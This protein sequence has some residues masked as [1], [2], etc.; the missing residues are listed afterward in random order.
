[1]R[2]ERSGG[3]R[4]L[5]SADDGSWA[6]QPA[7]ISGPFLVTASEAYVTRGI[8]LGA[9]AAGGDGARAGAGAAPAP[10]APVVPRGGLLVGA[11]SAPAQ[12]HTQV[13]VEAL[14]E[15]KLHGMAWSLGNVTEAA[16]DDGR[17]ILLPRG[18]EPRRRSTYIGGSRSGEWEGT[19]W[20]GVASRDKPGA[21]LARLKFLTSFSVQQGVETIELPDILAAKD[22]ERIV[23]PARLVVNGVTRVGNNHYELHVASFPVGDVQQWRAVREGQFRRGPRLLDAAGRELMSSGG[24][25]S[26]NADSYTSQLRFSSGVALGGGQGE[27]AKLVWEVPTAVQQFTV[28][29]EFENLPLP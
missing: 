4:L 28:P 3:G 17:S 27:P 10:P 12:D 24:S 29:V 14:F 19:V 22:V 9:D 25:S 18:A 20:L 8:R 21:R 13:Q 23:G 7:S 11:G 16:D 6:R 26:M 1:M 5:L 2:P 15:P